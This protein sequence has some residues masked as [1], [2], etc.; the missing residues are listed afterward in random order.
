MY[1]PR[2]CCGD[3]A[4]LD[5]LLGGR[6]ERRGVDER[7]ADAERARLHFLPHERPHAFELVGRR[8]P[9]VEPDDV[10]ANRRGADKR[11]D[12]LRHAAPLQ[13]LEVLAQGRPGDGVLEIALR[14]DAPLLHLFSEGPHRVSLAHDLRR[15]ALP[16]LSLR[17]SVREE[18][19]GGPRQHVD[20]AGGDG[21]AARVDRRARAGARE[22]ADGGD[23][24]AADPDVR[25]PSRSAGAVVHRTVAQD[26]VEG[27][28]LKGGCDSSDRKKRG[29][30]SEEE[31]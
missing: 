19:L 6:V 10:L 22:V 21:Q 23:P 28:R 16:D 8:L 27:F 12:V 15:H 20:E 13:L 26:Q 24:I 2:Y 18:R 5:Q 7:R 31:V 9:I 3:L 1:L 25:T 30:E 17:A 4:Q 29:A 14:P 11:R